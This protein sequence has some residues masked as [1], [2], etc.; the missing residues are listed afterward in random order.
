MDFGAS[1]FDSA[2]CL[3]GFFG[4]Y[5]TGNNTFQTR[6]RT[7]LQSTEE[8]PI[9]TTRLKYPLRPNNR[10]PAGKKFSQIRVGIKSTTE[11]LR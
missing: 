7:L 10:H 4:I 2:F 1:G 8:N 9:A 11:F 3:G 6:G 5:F